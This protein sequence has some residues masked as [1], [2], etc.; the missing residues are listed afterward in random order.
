MKTRPVALLAAMLAAVAIFAAAVRV[1]A[2]IN[3]ETGECLVSVFREGRSSSGRA[4]AERRVARPV[5]AGKAS[6]SGVTSRVSGGT[7]G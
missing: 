3:A 5:R 2:P 7:N 4:A 1:G 6:T